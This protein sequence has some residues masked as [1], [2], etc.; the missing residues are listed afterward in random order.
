L[1]ADP[2]PS[3]VTVVFKNGRSTVLYIK[4]FGQVGADKIFDKL[5][6]LGVSVVY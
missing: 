3:W 2:A 5:N 6:Q 1:F 4:P